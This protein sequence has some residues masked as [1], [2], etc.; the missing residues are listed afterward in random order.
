MMNEMRFASVS[1]PPPKWKPILLFA[2][3]CAFRVV[4]YC[5]LRGVRTHSPVQIAR[6]ATA[7]VFPR[8][9]PAR[10]RCVHRFL[11]LQG[12]S[13]VPAAVATVVVVPLRGGLVQIFPR[14]PV[15]PVEPVP[16]LRAG[17]REGRDRV[18]VRGGPVPVVLVR[19]AVSGRTRVV[20]LGT[21]PE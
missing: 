5:V 10:R 16:R 13:T 8:A 11:A 7:E 9:R 19:G 15:V 1:L 14:L 6:P 2:I 20:G 18:A 17:A 21:D 4:V 12:G 3:V